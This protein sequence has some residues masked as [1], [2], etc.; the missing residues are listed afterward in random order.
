M[1]FKERPSF[2]LMPK[3]YMNMFKLIRVAE[4]FGAENF[5][6]AATSWLEVD[7]HKITNDNNI[8]PVTQLIPG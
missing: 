6:K 1:V 3:N 8:R 4:Y 5:L 2:F 7:L